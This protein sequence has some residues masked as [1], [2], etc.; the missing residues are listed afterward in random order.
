MNNIFKPVGKKVS[1]N[2]KVH[3]TDPATANDTFT[4]LQET[5]KEFEG[6]DAATVDVALHGINILKK[7]VVNLSEIA[8]CHANGGIIICN[9]RL[10]IC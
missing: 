9:E 3:V 7:N 8:A 4:V 6:F 10:T 1:V 5:L 2:F